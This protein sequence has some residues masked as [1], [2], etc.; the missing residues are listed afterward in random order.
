MLVPASAIARRD[1]HSVVFVLEG[2]VVR[3]RTVNPAE[4]TFGD[5]RLLP[6]EVKPGDTVV[7]SPP[8]DLR[9]GSAVQMKAAKS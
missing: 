2:K 7:V 3:Q 6:T 5:L 1:G 9:D 4:Q 8:A